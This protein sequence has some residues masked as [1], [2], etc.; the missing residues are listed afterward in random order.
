MQAKNC[1]HNTDHAHFQVLIPRL[2][3]C[4]CHVL[5]LKTL[6]SSLQTYEGKPRNMGDLG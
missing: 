5:N 6:A 3:H 2:V 4:R 1:S